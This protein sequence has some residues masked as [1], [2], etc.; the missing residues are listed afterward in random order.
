MIKNISLTDLIK[1]TVKNIKIT[2]IAENRL[3]TT[4]D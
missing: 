1:D 2:L 3:M 4:K